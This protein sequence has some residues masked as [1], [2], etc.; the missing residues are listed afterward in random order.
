MSD[1][2]NTELK[3]S[4]DEVI[5]VTQNIR[6]DLIHELVKEGVPE[7]KDGRYL[8]LKVMEQADQTAVSNK[9]IVSD[10]KSADEDRK[11]ARYSAMVRRQLLSNV[12]NLEAVGDI[13]VPPDLAAIE[14]L[15]GETDVIS[16]ELNYEEFMAKYSDE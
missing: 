3:H 1:V 13:P 8:L 16:E 7:D 5:N 9:K 15:P 4:D 11:V 12:K 2:F 14:V 6:M 10:D